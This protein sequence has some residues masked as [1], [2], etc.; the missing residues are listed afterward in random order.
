MGAT[1]CCRGLQHQAWILCPELSLFL[2]LSYGR[3]RAQLTI[4]P[5]QD[6]GAE[7]FILDLRNNPVRRVCI[8]CCCRGV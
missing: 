3:A 7:G 2:P 4:G 1:P 8:C 5:A 6:D